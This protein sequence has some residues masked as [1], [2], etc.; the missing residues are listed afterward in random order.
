MYLKKVGSIIL[1]ASIVIW[2]LSYFPR[3]T[4]NTVKYKNDIEQADAKYNNQIKQ[5]AGSNL[6]QK[7]LLETRKIIA[8]TVYPFNKKASS[9]VNR[10]LE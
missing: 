8:L 7:Q 10:L 6:K 9:S 5:L 3:N 2:I 4:E 1:I